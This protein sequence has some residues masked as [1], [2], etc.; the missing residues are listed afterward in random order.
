M[1]ST[2]HFRLALAAIIALTLSFGACS[3]AT[4]EEST[5]TPEYVEPRIPTPPKGSYVVSASDGTTVRSLPGHDTNPIGRLADG[6][7]VG[8]TGRAFIID[9]ET[10]FEITKNDFVGWVLATDLTEVGG[11]GDEAE[12]LSET[13]TREEAPQVVLPQ[14]VTAYPGANLRLAP[15]GEILAEL[16]YGTAVTPNGNE[17]DGWVQVTAGD[18]LGWM[19]ADLIGELSTEGEPTDAEEPSK[20]ETKTESKVTPI[21]GHAGV[22]LRNAPGGDVIGGIPAGESATATGNVSDDWIEVTYN[23]VTG[24]AFGDIL[25]AG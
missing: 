14:M 19:W 2:S 5:G 4:V 12:V 25:V 7:D 24:W 15:E 13:Q 18:Q 1:R 11:S 3:G 6:S 16:A 23:G 10:W 20:T 9:D 21:D 8:I 17:S 22:N